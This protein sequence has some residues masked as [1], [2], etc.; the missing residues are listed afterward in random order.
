MRTSKINLIFEKG[1]VT[2]GKI[3]SQKIE[4]YHYRTDPN[5]DLAWCDDLSL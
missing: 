3:R 5:L 1:Q 4:S 2:L